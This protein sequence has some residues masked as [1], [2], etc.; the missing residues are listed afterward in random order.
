MESIVDA[1]RR[2]DMRP[3]SVLLASKIGSHCNFT[4]KL[5]RSAKFQLQMRLP[6]VSPSTELLAGVTR[7]RRRQINVCGSPAH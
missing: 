3:E 7:I 2:V 5:Y 6:D 4:I 1:L